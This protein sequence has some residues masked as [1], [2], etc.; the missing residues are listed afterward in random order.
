V[1]LG[2]AKE[3]VAVDLEHRESSVD[4]RSTK[5]KVAAMQALP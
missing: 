5:S 2:S 4:D 3:C 1:C